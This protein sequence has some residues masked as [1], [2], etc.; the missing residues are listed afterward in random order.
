MP[1]TC[2]EPSST[3]NTLPKH[4]RV[5]YLLLRSSGGSDNKNRHVYYAQTKDRT[6]HDSNATKLCKRIGV[7]PGTYKRWLLRGYV[8][9]P[10]GERV[11]IWIEQ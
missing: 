6:Y 1:D 8:V 2:H 5:S 7:S 11:K 3:D 9:T 10:A 4:L